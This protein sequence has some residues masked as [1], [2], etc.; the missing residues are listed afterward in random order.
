[1]RQLPIN[2][3]TSSEAATG[4]SSLP[5]LLTWLAYV[6]LPASYQAGPQGLQ[7]TSLLPLP[8]A[9]PLHSAP[10]LLFPASHFSLFYS[11]LQSELLLPVG[12]HPPTPAKLLSFLCW[13]HLV[14]NALM[15][16]FSLAK[17]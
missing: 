7:V 6:P 17:H 13:P 3:H 14:E 9:N 11:I 2:L 4:E 8:S 10:Q 12:P 5:Y 1:M 16:A 15:S